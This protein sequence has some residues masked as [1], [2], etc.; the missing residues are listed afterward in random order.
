[1]EE[2]T[3]SDKYTESQ[4]TIVYTILREASRGSSKTIRALTDSMGFESKWFTSYHYKSF[5]RAAQDEFFESQQDREHNYSLDGLLGRVEEGYRTNGFA[6]QATDFMGGWRLRAGETTKLL[7]GNPIAAAKQLKEYNIRSESTEIVTEAVERIRTSRDPASE[8]A[9]IAYQLQGLAQKGGSQTFTFREELLRASQMKPI[10]SGY[11]FVDDR[12][13]WNRF[14]G[15]GGFTP[16]ML[17]SILL[18]SENGKTSLAM[19]FAVKWISKGFPC[20]MLS[21]EE[22][23]QNLAV[24]ISNAYTGIPA[25]DIV[26]YAR[27]Q[28]DYPGEDTNKVIE[29][30]LATIQKYFLAY[31]ISGETAQIESIIRRHRI[32]FGE[33]LPMLVMVDHIGA[34]DSGKGNWSRGLEQIMKFFKVDIADKYSVAVNVFSQVPANME[35]DFKLKCYTT[36]KEARGSRAIRQWSDYMIAGA[37]HNGIPLPSYPHADMSHSTILQGI[38]NRFK[39]DARGRINWGVYNFD[40]NKGI[41]DYLITDDWQEQFSISGDQGD[42]I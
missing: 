19:A 32:Q 15:T 7:L 18:P 36:F 26:K 4:K 9:L 16:S 42:V 5:F 14:A 39:N 29:D 27:S 22:A 41:I 20:L 25:S 34:M 33:D 6:P 38:K 11:Q 1:M 21:A 3:R 37:R 10:S 8:V 40:T 23:R 2:V 28:A 24:R 17:T 31:E 35:E 30:A 12:L 13:L